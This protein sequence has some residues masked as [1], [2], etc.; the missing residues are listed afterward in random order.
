LRSVRLNIV[1]AFSNEY[2]SCLISNVVV[3]QWN[4]GSEY[5]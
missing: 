5:A 1:A 2:L 3:D 4:S